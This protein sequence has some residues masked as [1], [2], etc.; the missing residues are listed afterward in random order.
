MKTIRKKGSAEVGIAIVAMALLLLLGGIFLDSDPNSKSSYIK[1]KNSKSQAGESLAQESYLFYLNNTDIGRQSK[2]TESFP[3]LE[4]GSKETFNT[5][6][7]GSSFRLQ[8]NPFTAN[9][10][11][12]DIRFAEPE[13][14]NNYLL[15]FNSDRLSG[16]N[17]LI[18][19]VNGEPV[20]NTQAKD[21]DM[22]IV[23]AKK[24]T[25]NTVTLTFEIDKPRWYQLFN[26]NKIDIEKLRVVEAIQDKN[27]N[28]REF[29]FEIEKDFLERVY[30]DLV[31]S[32]EDT[33]NP[34]I[35]VTVNGFIVG[36]ENPDCDSRYNR[37]SLNVP[38]SILKN[39][40]ANSIIM[41]TEGYYKVA[42]SLNKIYF[43]DKDV[44]KFTINSFNDIVDVII[45]GDFDK[46]VIDLRLNS[47]TFSLARD[48]IKSIIPYL[49]FG[50][51]ELRILTKP[52]EIEELI[53]EK[54]EF[55]NN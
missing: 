2:V 42:Y 44:Y 40:G 54:N 30:V 53:V 5:I 41:E 1:D 55:Y 38:L 31:V 22:P 13:D 10:Y 27:N 45:Y 16:D 19:K 18:I 24:P 11:S 43:N 12:F 52:V 51:N 35:K 26:W 29:N 47:Q 15:Y 25:N 6:H 46:N 4:L 17:N 39:Q 20:V 33:T 7:V 50:T 21:S 14:V 9:S 34:P 8:A 28:E 3:N 48:E 36:N 23:I 37:I 49:R 32:C